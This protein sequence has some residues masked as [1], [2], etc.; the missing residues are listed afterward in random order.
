MKKRIIE[1]KNRLIN[2][3]NALIEE[4]EKEREEF[5]NNYP[6]THVKS[7]GYVLRENVA[8]FKEEIEAIKSFRQMVEK[9]DP[10]SFNSVEEFKD[11]VLK[12]LERMYQ[13]YT[14][15]RAGLR[16]VIECVKSTF[17]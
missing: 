12:E 9:M 13:S 2:K 6:K 14:L 16:I 10:E 8:T 4:I 1:Y 17:V 3:S 15:L 11:K 5:E 7:D